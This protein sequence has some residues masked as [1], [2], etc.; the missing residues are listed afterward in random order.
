MSQGEEGLKRHEQGG[1]GGG[2]N[3]FDMFQ[4]FFGRRGGGGGG[5][6]KGPDVNI[7]IEVTLKDLYLGKQ[8][9]T[10]LLLP[11]S[12]FTSQRGKKR[13]RGKMREENRAL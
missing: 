9:Y 12:G 3:P 13:R 2:S 5:E 7:D 8:V 10:F 6:N 11:V 4:Q 1:G